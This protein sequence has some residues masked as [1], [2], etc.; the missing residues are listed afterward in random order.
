MSTPTPY[1]AAPV[2]YLTLPTPEKP[3]PKAV[4][5][6]ILELSVPQT[7]WV[8]DVVDGFYLVKAAY[9]ETLEPGCWSW[10]SI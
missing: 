2:T 10:A 9:S 3:E 1:L 8:L 7:L 4:A 6:L 5:A